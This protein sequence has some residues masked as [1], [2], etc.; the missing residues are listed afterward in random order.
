[1]DGDMIFKVLSPCSETSIEKQFSWILAIS[2]A[3]GPC[4]RAVYV[5]SQQKNI[6]YIMAL[7]S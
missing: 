4:L 2:T 5:K 7:K 1:M 6:L 3:F